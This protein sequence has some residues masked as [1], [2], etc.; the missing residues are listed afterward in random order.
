[1]GEDG[2][3]GIDNLHRAIAWAHRRD[4]DAG[5]NPH[6]SLAWCSGAFAPV[7]VEP[8]TWVVRD[9][10]LVHSLIGL[11]RYEILARFPLACPD[12]HGYAAWDD[13]MR[14]R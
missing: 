13:R 14:V 2:V 1:V 6:M 11:S 9:F 3:V 5:F 7:Y 8:L 10:A 12:S 4:P